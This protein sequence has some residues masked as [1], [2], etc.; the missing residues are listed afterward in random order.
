MATKEEYEKALKEMNDA[1]YGI[2]FLNSETRR[3]DDN[4]NLLRELVNECFEEK[5]ETNYEHYKDGVIEII[6]SHLALVNGEPRNCSR[7]DCSYCDF[8]RHGGCD[9][10][11]GEV[12]EWLK[13]PY[14][15]PTYK[16]N[17]FEYDLLKSYSDIYS[18]NAFNSLSGMKEKGYFKG[19]DDNKKIGDILDNCE[20]IK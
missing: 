12:E 10:K 15:K 14:K 6:N 11:V 1:F 3:F 18:F 17:Q 9:K 7:I 16:L 13:Q 20:V 5:T 4:L 2:T 19:I 8:N